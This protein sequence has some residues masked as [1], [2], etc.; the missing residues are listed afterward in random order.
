MVM[1]HMTG[2]IPLTGNGVFL[3]TIHVWRH[4]GVVRGQGSYPYRFSYNHESF[5]SFHVQAVV[6]VMLV[7]P[8]DTS[9]LASSNI[10]PLTTIPTSLNT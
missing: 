2:H 6:P 7:K 9:P 1:R 3:K 5:I 8:R 10:F 4:Q